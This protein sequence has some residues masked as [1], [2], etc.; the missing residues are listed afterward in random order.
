[1]AERQQTIEMQEPKHSLADVE[2]RVTSSSS[3][4]SSSSSSDD[5]SGDSSDDI[6]HRN[7]L[8]TSEDDDAIHR[9][10]SEEETSKQPRLSIDKHI[11]ALCDQAK[12]LT[13]ERESTT[14]QMHSLLD[15]AIE[16]LQF[17]KKR[18]ERALQLQIQQIEESFTLR[19]EVFEQQYVAKVADIQREMHAAIQHERTRAEGAIRAAAE[20]LQAKAKPQENDAGDKSDTQQE[21]S[22]VS[23]QRAKLRALE[24]RLALFSQESVDRITNELKNGSASARTSS[25]RKQQ[26]S[27]RT[28]ERVSQTRTTND[29]L[30][31]DA[32]RRERR[33]APLSPL[34]K[35]RSYWRNGV[36][37]EHPRGGADESCEPRP[38]VAMD[39]VSARRARD[40]LSSRF[41][42][43]EEE[44]EL[45]HLKN[46]IGLANDWMEETHR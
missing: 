43:P 44:R 41:L 7:S 30:S 13:V 11:H 25:Y 46:S 45:R 34:R 3:A 18:E 4:M 32:E 6:M 28:P 15:E 19:L 23:R 33:P 37:L 2:N 42:R 10:T 35:N 40:A 22:P 16:E 31:Q 36:S 26:S 38:R 5:E 12:R 8:S 24:A 1:M 17:L 9:S 21:L 14:T 29:T 20:Q 39:E 27:C